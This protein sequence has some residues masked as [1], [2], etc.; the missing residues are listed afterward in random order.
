[1]C[2]GIARTC[3]RPD[4]DTASR[5]SFVDPLPE[6]ARVSEQICYN[7]FRRRLSLA[8]LNGANGFSITGINPDDHSGYSVRSAGDVNADGIADLIIGAPNANS[9]RGAS[10][11]VFGSKQIGSQGMFSLSNLNG[12]NGFSITGINPS[13][14]SASSVSSAG[15]VNADGIADLIIGAAE[16]NDGRGASYVVFGS[17]QIG[18]QGMLQSLLI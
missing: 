8:N 18:S 7:H 1:M 3:N 10:Y 9:A 14:Y 5:N 6:C 11:V 12:L 13:D 4:T 15:D 17:K 16:A 2:N